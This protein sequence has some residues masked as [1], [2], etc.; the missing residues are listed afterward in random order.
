MERDSVLAASELGRLIAVLAR[1]DYEVVGP[2]VRDGAIVY[3]HVDSIEDLPIGWT[4]EQEPGHYRLKRRDDGA[5]F[6]YAV[7]PQSWKKYLHPSNIRLWS[8]EREN[9]TFRILNQEPLP[10]KRYAFLGVRSCDL[11]AIGVQDRVL[12]EDRH[13]DPIYAG[14]RDGVFIVA[15]QCT[16]AVSTCFCAS[17]GTGPHVRSGYDLALTELVGTGEHRFLVQAATEAGRAVLADLQHDKAT[18]EDV[19][20]AQAA[21]N[22]AA[23][24]QVRH[25][26]T[27]DIRELLYSNFEHP[28]WDKV[29]ERCLACTNCTLVCPTCFCTTVE[30]TS[31]ISGDHAERW[32]RLDSCFTLDFS[33]IHGGSVRESTKARYRQWLTHKLASWIDQFGTSGC[34]GCG[35]CIAWCPVGID[36]TEEL[37]AIRDGC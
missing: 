7:G 37:Q 6:G 11:A 25:M 2:V 36:I 33:Y 10:K 12:L 14:R 1:R 17:M 22:G 32:R 24:E 13:Q 4:D 19:R 5:L 23:A 35:R 28:R 3:D 34:V 15:V 21:V 8:A 29:A 16:H 27:T 26:D 31:D 9:G 18:D 30:D 20:L